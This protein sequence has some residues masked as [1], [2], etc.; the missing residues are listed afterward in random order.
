MTVGRARSCDRLRGALCQH[1]PHPGCADDIQRDRFSIGREVCPGCATWGCCDRC[2]TIRTPLRGRRTQ[3]FLSIGK[4]PAINASFFA[5]LHGF[6]CASRFRAALNESHC[7]TYT[8]DTGS[9]ARVYFAPFPELSL[10]T[11]LDGLDTRS[12][13]QRHPCPPTSERTK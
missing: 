8:S 12:P 2:V 10:G 4:S 11:P 1:V 9:R 6:N 13:G 7:S 5:R 3:T